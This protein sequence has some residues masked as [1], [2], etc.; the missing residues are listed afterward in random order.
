LKGQQKRNEYLLIFRMDI[1]T[2]EAQPSKK[3]MAEYMAHWMGWINSISK[4]QKLAVGGNHLI[5]NGKVLQPNGI[6]QN[7]AYV[8]NNESV[9]GYIITFAKDE[10]D[11][12][13]IA[14]ECPILQGEGTS[15]E[16][17]QIATPESMKSAGRSKR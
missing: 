5:P 13:Q 8:S 9:A 7:G 17:R 14:K 4:Q 3:Q 12:V 6:I 15:V 11:A 10:D 16:I 1:L 2:P